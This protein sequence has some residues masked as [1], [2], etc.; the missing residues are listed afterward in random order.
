MIDF[1]LEDTRYETREKTRFRAGGRVLKEPVTAGSEA[2]FA[3]GRAMT[4]VSA[5]AAV[6]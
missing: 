2:V 4:P 3:G 6:M 5:G 1:L